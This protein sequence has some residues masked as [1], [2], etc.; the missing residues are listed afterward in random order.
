MAKMNENDYIVTLRC[1]FFDILRPEGKIRH[2]VKYLC[3]V[4]S[5]HLDFQKRMRENP[6]IVS[7]WSQY[8]SSF[9]IRSVGLG[10]ETIKVAKKV[11]EKEKKDEVKEN[12]KV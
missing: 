4:E 7:C 2:G 6:E 10:I 9:D 12:E 3:D 1:Y 11:T 8:V 5:A